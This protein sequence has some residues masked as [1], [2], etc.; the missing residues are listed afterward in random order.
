MRQYVT[1][2][3]GSALDSCARTASRAGQPGRN[4]IKRN[5]AALPAYSLLLGYMAI[6]AKVKSARTT[7]PWRRSCDDYLFY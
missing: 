3:L 7:T 5:M 4:V 1:V 6:A 2:A